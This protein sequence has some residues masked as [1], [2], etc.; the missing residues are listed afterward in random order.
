MNKIIFI[1]KE[2]ELLINIKYVTLK[3]LELLVNIKY[4][5]SNNL[6]LKLKSKHIS[7]CYIIFFNI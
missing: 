3:E 7:N 4:L 2:L 5:Y 1:L 6:I